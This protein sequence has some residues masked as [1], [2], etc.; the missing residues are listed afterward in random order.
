MSQWTADERSVNR[1]KNNCCAHTM[2]CIP[3]RIRGAYKGKPEL[4]I[5][6]KNDIYFTS[7]T[8]IISV[9]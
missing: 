2:P 5:S 3:D 7:Y 8:K 6:G 1:R 9:F 4:W